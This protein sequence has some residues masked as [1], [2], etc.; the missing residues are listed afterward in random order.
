M[1]VI[2]HFNDFK[3]VCMVL[4]PKTQVFFLVDNIVEFMM[5]LIRFRD[6]MNF[7]YVFFVNCNRRGWFQD[8]HNVP[9]GD[10]WFKERDMKYWV[11]LKVSGNVELTQL[12]VREIISF[13]TLES[14]LTSTRQIQLSFSHIYNFTR[15]YEGGTQ[16]RTSNG[17]TVE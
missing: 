14:L 7:S 4:Q 10:I 1:L 11:E 13:S 8:S 16:K 12:N 9:R 5:F 17:A 3:V 15:T 2:E 6:K